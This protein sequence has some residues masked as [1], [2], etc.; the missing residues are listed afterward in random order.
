MNGMISRYPG[1]RSPDDLV[2]TGNST[3][4]SHIVFDH[5]DCHREH[6]QRQQDQNDDI[7]CMSAAFIA[8]HESATRVEDEPAATACVLVV[9][10]WA[11]QRLQGGRP[12]GK[13]LWSN[14][15]DPD[16]R[17]YYEKRRGL[18]ASA[19]EFLQWDS[20]TLPERAEDSERL[21]A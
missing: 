6:Q 13:S 5:P 3:P 9:S 18:G 1:R 4:F 12:S 10:S 20:G 14:H 21:R 8:V 15:G 17:I 2:V 11:F 16:V 7:M 19:Q